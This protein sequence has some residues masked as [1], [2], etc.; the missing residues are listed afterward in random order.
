MEIQ[1]AGAGAVL[2]P[3]PLVTVCSIPYDAGYR[4]LG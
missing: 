4:A 1:P 3:A 2:V